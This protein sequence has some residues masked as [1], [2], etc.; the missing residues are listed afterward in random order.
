MRDSTRLATGTGF[1]IDD[2]N[3]CMR[4]ESWT[5]PESSA[6]F[7]L[8]FVRRGVYRLRVRDRETVADPV[9]AYAVRAGDEQSIAH[10]V[11]V[12]DASTS[13]TLSPAL[14]AEFVPG[15]RSAPIGPLFTSGRVDLAHRV[16]YARASEGADGFELAD[17]VLQLAADTLG[18]PAPSTPSPSV[19]R[20][21]MVDG[22]REVLAGDPV[23]L[24]LEGL[25]GKVCVSPAYLSR[26]FRRET[27]HT[28]T[29]FRNRLRVR[30]VLDRLEQGETNLSRLATDLG[31]ADHA[32]LTR[33]VREEIGCAPSA[34]RRLLTLCPV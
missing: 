10:R 26:I 18:D 2:L 13:I 28:L 1:S 6:E 25:A 16:L 21:R 20:R 4:T 30:I 8:V 3:F 23:T 5:P 17:R 7:K 27:G 24:G 31:F 32:H 14:L 29:R 15:Q 11:G 12:R 33:T 22:A 34:A 9:T 19:S